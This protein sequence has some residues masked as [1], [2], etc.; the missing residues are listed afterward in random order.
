MRP[1]PDANADS[2]SITKRD[3]YSD[4]N[5]STYPDTDAYSD[6]NA[7]AVLADADTN[8]NVTAPFA[9]T[10][11]N[12]DTQGSVIVEGERFVIRRIKRS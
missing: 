12:A 9:D 3:T 4:P 2:N 8:S 10:D 11:S 5:C 6:P 7:A 1:K